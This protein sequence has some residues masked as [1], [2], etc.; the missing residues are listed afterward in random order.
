MTSLDD[1][2]VTV[3]R[4]MQG[5]SVDGPASLEDMPRD[6]MNVL[7][8]FLTLPSYHAMALVSKR[9]QASISKASHLFMEDPSIQNRR[10][11]T[12]TNFLTPCRP[13]STRTIR[14]DER[15]FHRMI[16][17]FG[18]LRVLE[19]NGISPVGDSLFRILNESPAADTIQSL[20]LDGVNLTYWCPDR[21]ELPHLE[22]LRI[23]GGSIRTSLKNIFSG[24]LSLK[25]LSIGQCS[26][27]RDSQ[28]SDMATN[29]GHC[30][31]HLSLH[32]CSRI[33]KPV[34]RFENLERLSL[35]A[36]FALTDLPR[37]SCPTLR[38]LDLS[39][40]I[41]VHSSEVQK[42]VATLPL[43][44][45]LLLVK[46][47]GLES[48][49]L[50]DDINPLLRVVNVAYSPQLHTLRMVCSSL[51]SL[52]TSGCL[53][54]TTLLMDANQAPLIYLNISVLPALVRLDLVSLHLQ[55]L[56]LANCRRLN[57][58]SVHCPAL[59]TVNVSGSR[60]V[61]LRFCKS[62]RRVILND[63]MVRRRR[64]AAA[65]VGEGSRTTIAPTFFRTSSM[66]Q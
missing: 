43:L 42:L 21:L 11:S 59:Q 16:Q 50:H 26:S 41:R 34:L 66:I 51:E 17:R 22:H 63:W 64:V 13:G 56:H 53:S 27:L 40:C 60:T 31:R 61:A 48:L 2:T 3:S 7:L 57:E 19:L 9:I 23:T 45:E 20:S 38:V 29:L 18:S 6:A 32:Q 24:N 15:Y 36:S 37:F 35:M 65:S 33:K 8:S 49:A 44:E 52:L 1:D 12:L 4:R 30:L 46:C 54:L 25:S 5:V 47:V 28:V 55:T 58:V 39:F 14:F 10:V 62:V